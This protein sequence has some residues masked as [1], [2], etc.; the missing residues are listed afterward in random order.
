MFT[1]TSCQK[2][3]LEVKVDHKGLAHTD[4]KKMR[5]EVKADQE[6]LALTAC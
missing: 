6:G 4:C 1:L 2:N 3:K 5:L